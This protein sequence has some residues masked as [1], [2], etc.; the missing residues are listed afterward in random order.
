MNTAAFTLRNALFLALAG[1]TPAWAGAPPIM[2]YQGQLQESGSPVSGNRDMNI[3]LCSA[4]SGPSCFPTGTQGITATNGLYRTTFTAPSTVD[5]NAGAWYLEVEV[6]PS[7]GPLT[8]LSPREQLT[9]SPYA[10]AASS[11]PA[12]GILPGTVADG[13]NFAGNVGIGNDSPF[14]KVDVKGALDESLAIS[15][16]N[17]SE[18]GAAQSVL[19]LGNSLSTTGG[20]LILTGSGFNQTAGPNVLGV[21]NYLSGPIRF[22]TGDERM[23]IMPNGDIGVGTTNPTQK[24]DVAGTVNAQG[25]TIAGIPISGGSQWTTSG[26]EISYTSGVVGIG[27]MGSPTGSLLEVVGASP[28]GIG[29][30]S[31]SSGSPTRLEL[32]RTGPDAA[33]ALPSGS[34][35]FM[36]GSEAGDLILETFNAGA[37]IH[38]ATGNGASATARLTVENA[39]GNVGIG[40]LNPTSRLQVV[41]LPVYANNAAALAGGLTAGAFYRTGGDPD[42]VAVVH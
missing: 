19:F 16:K 3:N 42:L 14:Y 5:L 40:T 9:S 18:G 26:S 41:G 1:L 27:T 6:G 31:G 25:F 30:L 15:V 7:G 11:V 22:Y 17:T 24:L 37:K 35:E 28:T 36:T 33:M 32:G 29:I 21:D 13:V 8:T 12:G 39:N 23:R 20:A 4:L 10:I 34:G 2:T 38:L